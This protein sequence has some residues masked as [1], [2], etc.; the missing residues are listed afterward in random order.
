M[1]F[2]DRFVA[3]HASIEEVLLPL[4]AVVCLGLA[5]KML[6]C[7]RKCSTQQCQDESGQLWQY[8]VLTFHLEV[9]S[10]LELCRETFGHDYEAEMMCEAELKIFQ[11]FD[12]ELN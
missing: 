8:Q 4:I 7:K 3:I 12:Y 10:A 5:E 2:F 6:E 1:Q 9:Y 11:Q